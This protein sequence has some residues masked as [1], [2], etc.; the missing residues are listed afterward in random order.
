M[1]ITDTAQATRET[2]EVANKSELVKLWLDVISVSSR[3]EENWRK[4]AQNATDLYRQSAT[5]AEAGGT[6]KK[7][8]ILHSN[9]ETIVPAL[10]N[11]TPVPDVRRRYNDPDPTGK[12]V[13]D[14][15]ERCLSYSVDSYDFD[16]TMRLVTKDMELPGRGTA[17]IRY[18]PYLCE[19]E[20]SVDY[21]EVYCEHVP[22]RNYRRGPANEYCDMPWEAFE[23]FLTREELVKLNPKIG[24]QVTLDVTV[25]PENDKKDGNNPP[26]IFK[27]A[28]VWEIW[29]KDSRKV[30]FISTSYKDEPLL[31]VDDP[32]ELEN[33]FCTPRPVYG[34]QT[35]DSLVPIVPYEIYKAQAQELERISERIIVLTEAVKAKAVY[36]GRLTEMERLS[37][38]E[39]AEN[40]ALENLSVL[41]DGSKLNDHIWFYPIQEI[42]LALE[43]CFEAR[44]QIK[45]TIYEV[46]GI[47]DILRGQTQAS[48][49]ATA[50]QIKQNWGSLRIQQKQAEIQRFARDLFRLKAELFCSKFEPQVLQLMTGIQIAPEVFQL[51]RNDKL[52]S[53]RVD[54]ESD[55][56]VKADLTKN[57]QNMTMFLQGVAQYAQAMGPIVMADRSMMPA[58]ME[59]F[60]AFSRNFKLGKQAEDAIEKVIQAAQVAAQNPQPEK[61]DPKL[62]AAKVKAQADI[63]KTQADAQADQQ[64][65]QLDMAAKQQEHQMKMQLMEAELNL[66]VQELQI[67]QQKLQMQMREM[68]MATQAKER[69]A[70]IQ[71]ASDEHKASLGMQMTEHKH[72]MGMEMMAQKAKQAK[73]QPRAKN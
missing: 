38:A 58:A 73:Q 22:W 33:F 32:L 42:V 47:S 37:S 36:D 28:R 49:T 66:K 59:V 16:H 12:Q 7:F 68:Q 26:E 35:G 11:S 64:K 43:K 71:A 17:R 30:L 60:A 57:Q 24:G 54:I 65:M 9:I 72:E 41:A 51:L 70:H 61:P 21:Q 48:E 45:S 19:D 4:A 63:Q 67:D 29:D 13:A 27:R 34:I 23:L 46:T 5:S 3:E 44:E 6:N 69:Q 25:V 18:K 39:D 1:S 55:S 14:I 15:L 2:D 62:E 56:T 50:Q 53:F 20:S 10:Y 52:R 8:N 40:I 31:E